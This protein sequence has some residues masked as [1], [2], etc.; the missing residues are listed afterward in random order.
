MKKYIIYFLTAFLW[1]PCK[2]LQSGENY[3]F[4]TFSPEGGFLY[5]GVRSILQDGDGF[6]WM[7]MDNELCRFDGYEYKYYYTYFTKL[8]PEQEWS[9]YDIAVNSKGRLFIN[10]GNGLYTYNKIQDSFQ[11]IWE[12]RIDAV[13]IDSKDHIWVLKNYL[14]H[15]LDMEKHQLQ[16]PSFD[17]KIKY[18]LSPVFC[19]NNEDL[20]LCS[21]GNIF[22][23]NYAKNE[24][25]LCFSLP[26]SDRI[27]HIKAY[28]GKLWVMVRDGNIY[29]I[30]LPT[31]TI[32]AQFDFFKANGTMPLRAFYID[33]Y[34][35]IWIGTLNGLYILDPLT[36]KY[37]HYEHSPSDPF[38]LPNNSIWT[39]QE[40]KHKNVWMGAYSGSVCYV[41]L[42]E[43]MPFTTWL[44]QADGLNHSP[45][46]AFAE[47]AQSLWIGT[48]GGGINRMNKQTGRFTYLVH[49]ND[50]NSLSHNN[51][52]S[53]VPDKTGN[54]WIALYNGGLDCYDPKNHR[55]K[56]F[57]NKPKDKNS[58]LYNDIRK[59]VLEGDSGLWI[60]YQFRKEIISFY[61][62]KSDTFTHYDFSGKSRHY[63]FDMLRGKN[64]NL[65]I[66]SSEKI[67]LLNVMTKAIKAIPNINGT[68]MNFQTFCLDDSGNLWLGTIGNGLVKY[69]S[70]TSE[71]TFHNQWMKH[72]VSSIYNICY[73]EERNLWLG[74]NNGLIR[75]EI[76]NNRFPRYDTKDG[77]Q[78]QVYYPLAS[79][80]G[81]NGELYFGGTNGFTRVKPEEIKQNTYKSRVI[82][83]DFFIHYAPAQAV[84]E[85]NTKEI[86]LNYKQENFGFAFSS[87]N[88]LVPEKNLFR[89]RLKGYYDEWIETPASNRNV[90]YTKVKPGSYSFEVE[91]ANNDGIWSGNI[92][93]VKIV[94]KPAP[95]LSAPA[96]IA[97]LLICIVI[98]GLIIQRYR[99]R[100]KLEMQLYLEN[101]EKTKQDE[102]HRAQMRFFTN[103]SHDF[104]TPLS[105]IIASLEK[106]RMEGLKEYYYRILSRNARRLLSLV[107]EIMDIRTLDNGKM[108]LKLQETNV[109][110]CVKE[111][112]ADF[113]DYAEQR[114]LEFNLYCEPGFPAS[115]NLDKTVVEK[116]I[117]NLLNNS[118]RFTDKGGRIS[119]ELYSDKQ[120]FQS[121]FVNQYTTT[122]DEGSENNCVIAIRDTGS[123]IAKDALP[124]VFKRFYKS[125]TSNTDVYSSTGIGLS[126]VKSLVFLHQGSIMIF[127]EE[128]KGTDIAVCLPLEPI[129]TQNAELLADENY[130]LTAKEPTAT[131][132]Q[133]EKKR[134]LLV[135]DNEDLRKL[136]SDFLA[137]DY[138]VVAASDGMEAEEI[139]SDQL[140]DIVLSDIMMP[141]KDGIELCAEIKENIETSHIPVILLTAKTGIE[142]KIEG[143][144]S[145]ADVYLEKPVDLNL[146]KLSIRNL[147]NHQQQIKEY[148][149][150]HY[151]SDN[152]T[153]ASNE[154]DHKFIQDFVR[155]IENNMTQ[156]VLDVSFIASEL[157]MSRSKLYRKI[158]AMTG[159]SIVEFILKRRLLK[160]ANLMI[161]KDLS[162]R[163]I[164]DDV[165]IESHS[166]FTNAF[167]KEFGETPSAFV[168]SHKKM[169]E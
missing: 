17:S 76:A 59:I 86:V 106:L 100:K 10:T 64:N 127:S 62:F 48:E 33:K 31:L 50:N 139:L 80:K 53:I 150:K 70:S 24:F 132:I 112:A 20:Y 91:A 65:W 92:Q 84:F 68:F 101:I 129:E 46:S 157:S 96:Y 120:H 98:T 60:A 5:D 16:T 28:K 72:N 102:I 108:A 51:V 14:W 12:E 90:Q 93:S 117:M 7:L 159:M 146:L 161:E 30:D 81:M 41:N 149:A 27:L 36:G 94:R 66:L 23:Y 25:S 87:D 115:L 137:A 75:Y 110:A 145:G 99:E 141:R 11:R 88:Y 103:I 125:E 169:K 69:N 167:K 164:M 3:R 160:A 148:Y 39:I 97:Y 107:N 163:E 6:I 109:Y 71:Y 162:M 123:G 153:V 49:T 122:G 168:S 79:M 56:H 54:I 136:L 113:R 35:H 147:F 118:F 82:I 142:N 42:D 155:T 134:I 4:R 29:K 15:I 166:Y 133:N 52:K 32:E 111:I 43:Q 154:R 158:K 18:S 135:E 34:G 144:D 73:D 13:K 126:L 138:K 104:K 124:Q 8:N 128:G 55:F 58:L 61:S 77:V 74:T 131:F 95:W 116:I 38:S 45:V 21:F 85:S 130:P 121:S 19:L 78:G 67:Y 2:A 44:P 119:I 1:F 165:G 140:I 40:D 47:D 151:Y 89:Y 63:I 57:K 152:N 83:S 37:M 9:L 143:V 105:L 22:R 156:P 114:D 26:V